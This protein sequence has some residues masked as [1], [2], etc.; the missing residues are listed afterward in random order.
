MYD[1]FTRIKSFDAVTRFVD[2]AAKDP[3][4]LAIKMTLYRVSPTS[5]IAQACAV[6]LKRAKR[7]RCLSSCRR[8]STR[9]RISLGRAPWKKSA[10]TSFMAWWVTKPTAKCV[11]WCARK[12]TASGDTVIFA[13]GNYNVRTAGIYS[14]LGPVHMPGSH[15]RQD[16]TELFNLLT[17]YTRPQKFNHLLLAPTRIARAFH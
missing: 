13:T 9:K 10:L 5:P 4:V 1:C 3:K 6:P 2:E 7:C 14:D 15:S 17:G 12:P 8:D 16:L 11:W